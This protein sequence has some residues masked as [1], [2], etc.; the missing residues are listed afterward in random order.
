VDAPL[1][2]LLTSRFD[3]LFWKYRRHTKAWKVAQLDAGHISMLMYL[4]AAD[5]GLGAFVTAAIND[6]VVEEALDLDPVV[7]GA[8]AVVGF[9]ARDAAGTTRELTELD[10]SP[11][12]RRLRATLHPADRDGDGDRDEPPV[13]ASPDAT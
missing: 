13:A 2:V 11:V 1:L 12:M 9:G 5:L 10:P 3:R 6:R 8:T 7:E 4:S